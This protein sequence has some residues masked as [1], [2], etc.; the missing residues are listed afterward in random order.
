MAVAPAAAANFSIPR[1]YDTDISWVF[2]GNHSM[3]CQQKLLPS[4]LQIYDEKKRDK[5]EEPERG[6]EEGFHQHGGFMVE[7]NVSPKN[8]AKDVKVVFQ[9]LLW[10]PPRHRIL[11]PSMNSKL[12]AR[13][14]LGDTV[15]LEN[16]PQIWIQEDNQQFTKE[17]DAKTTNGILQKQAVAHAN[18]PS[19][20]PETSL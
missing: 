18:P 16:S 9:S 4:S 3:S 15:G 19:G 7:E 10:D 14:A 1:R 17:L 8:I 20:G 12:E 6:E 5:E 2:N 13:F 11:S